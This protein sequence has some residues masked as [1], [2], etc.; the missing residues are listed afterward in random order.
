MP[1]MPVFCNLLLVILLAGLV[2]PDQSL[3]WGPGAHM[4]TGNWIL[5]NL[6][7]LPIPVAVALMRYPG[8]FLH[9]ALSA[10]IFIG[11]GSRAKKGHSHNWESG[12]SLLAKADTLSRMAYAYG[13]LAHLAADTVAHNVFVPGL[14]HTIPGSGRIAHVY[15]EIQADRLLSWDKADALGVFREKVSPKMAAMLRA[16]MRQK[17]LPFWIKTHLFR[18][19]ISLGGSPFWRGSMRLL[20]SLVP[21]HERSKLLDRMLT[22]STRAIADV[23]QKKEDSEILTLDPIG[24]DALAQ[25]RTPHRTDLLVRGVKDGLL[26]ALPGR[27]ASGSIEMPELHIAVPSLLERIPPVCT[28][29]R[30]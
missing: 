24:A 11:K 4:V 18:K 27:Q 8:Q 12:F 22:L 21:E 30:K 13:Y 5:Q 14:L 9:G 17:A 29:E 26:R 10:D 1:R 16:S 2:F 3:A 20:D 19:S 15:L 23:L 28:I 6:S 25:A 7:A